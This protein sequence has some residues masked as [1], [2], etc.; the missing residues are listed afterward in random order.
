[1]SDRSAT[2]VRR[3]P[4]V[5]RPAPRPSG[6]PRPSS[7]VRKAT[8]PPPPP[9]RPRLVSL[10]SIDLEADEP[11]RSI[12]PPLPRAARRRL[13]GEDLIATIFE[14]VHALQFLGDALE[15][16]RFCLSMLNTFLPCRTSLLHM[17]DA[18]RREFMVVSARGQGADDAV[19]KRQSA[20]DP[21]LR[22]AMP[23]G[24][25][26]AW[27][28]LLA[29]PSTSLDRFATLERVC[30]VLTAPVVHG[31]RYLGAIESRGYSVQCPRL[32]NA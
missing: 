12:A 11:P 14:E 31:G 24:V 5:P 27:N 32:I 20:E 21:L 22:V 19:L 23:R 16:S 6:A 26:F 2:S 7:T 17:Y 1:M 8:A 13:T 15:A 28:N 3:S 29:A 30:R 18:T 4:L 25:A 9:V 10:P